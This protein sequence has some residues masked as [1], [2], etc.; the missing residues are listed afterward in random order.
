MMTALWPLAA[1]HLLAMLLV[2]L[3]FALLVAI[4][5]WQRQIQIGA[6]LLVIGLGKV[7]SGLSTGVI[8]TYWHGYGRRNWGFGLSPWRLRR[9]P[10]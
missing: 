1:G 7:S 5:E 4:V 6:S 2:I 3:P 9:V 10:D 8:H